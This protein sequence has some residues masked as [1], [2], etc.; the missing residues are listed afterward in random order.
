MLINGHYANILF[1]C[2]KKKV[3]D[4]LMFVGRKLYDIL[5]SAEDRKVTLMCYIREVFWQTTN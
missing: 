5:F 1:I 3:I 4:K 2:Y